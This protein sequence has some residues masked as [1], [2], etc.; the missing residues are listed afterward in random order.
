[1]VPS[2]HEKPCFLFS[3]V[4]KRW[5]CTGIWSFLYYQ[6][7]WYLLFPKIWSYSLGKKERW[8]FPKNYMEIWCF[9]QTFWKDGL[10]K[11]IALEYDLFRNIW[12]DGISFFPKINFFFTRKMKDDLSQKKKKVMEIWCFLYI[13]INVTNMILPFCQKWYYGISAEI[14]YWLTF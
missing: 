3:N 5:S 9:L 6:E 10:S 14:P 1:M 12:K 13:C 2:V 8:P 11:K 7:R 4:L